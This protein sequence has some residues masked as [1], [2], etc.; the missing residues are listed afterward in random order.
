[1]KK[2]VSPTR[3]YKPVSENR[4]APKVPEQ[5]K[6]IDEI[7]L[8]LY[9]SKQRAARKR[10]LMLPAIA[11]IEGDFDGTADFPEDNVSEIQ[12]LRDAV[13]KLQEGYSEQAQE[14]IE[15]RCEIDRLRQLVS[16]FVAQPLAE[17]IPNGV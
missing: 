17:Q 6:Q 12:M 3:R 1:M 14:I 16:K 5:N 4:A 11:T 13:Q 9:A 8:A 7:E 15:L 10:Q 2:V